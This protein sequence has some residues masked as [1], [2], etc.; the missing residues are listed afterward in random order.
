MFIDSLCDHGSLRDQKRALKHVE[1]GFQE[2]V[3]CPVDADDPIWALCESS[4]HSYPCAIPLDPV[5]FCIIVGSI[6]NTY[7]L[8]AAITPWTLRYNWER[9]CMKACQQV[10]R[11]L[12]PFSLS[13]VAGICV[14]EA[15]RK[16]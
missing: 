4:V 15:T 1:Y 11:G 8:K 14:Q 12:C 16:S 9:S 6:Q 13:P 10:T 3:N 2:V 5:L 7:T